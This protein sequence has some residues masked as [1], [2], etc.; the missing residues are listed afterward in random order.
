M[1]TRSAGTSPS[2]RSSACT[3]SGRSPARGSSCFG[4]CG[5]DKGQK[6]VPEP[7]ARIAAQ[8]LTPT[9]PAVVTGG[10]GGVAQQRPDPRDELGG[11]ERFGQERGTEF[12]RLVQDAL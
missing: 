3:S 6:R 5:V 4:R 12:L 1:S 7:P 2:R 8:A 10:W 9:R 11:A